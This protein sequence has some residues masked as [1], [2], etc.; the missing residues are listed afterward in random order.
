MDKLPNELLGHVLAFLP[1]RCLA[2]SRRVSLRWKDLCERS[3]C[4]K[5]I[6]NVVIACPG[7]KPFIQGVDNVLVADQ[8]STS[9][10]LGFL[11]HVRKASITFARKIDMK[12]RDERVLIVF[13]ESF[14]KSNK[15]TLESLYINNSSV[16][17]W[18]CLP[19][20][21]LL[22]KFFMDELDAQTLQNLI[23]ACPN[24]EAIRFR[25][26]ESYSFSVLPKGLK[27]MA[28]KHVDDEL[29]GSLDLTLLA[30]SP[31][32]QTIEML[33][34]M[35]L[36]KTVPV[37][38]AMPNLRNAA[39]RVLEEEDMETMPRILST[40][41]NIQELRLRITLRWVDEDVLLRFWNR[42]FSHLKNLLR[43]KLEGC[44]CTQ[45]FGAVG[46]NCTKLQYIN[47]RTYSCDFDQNDLLQLVALDHLKKIEIVTEKLWGPLTPI[48]E[49]AEQ[50]PQ[51]EVK[52]F[53]AVRPM[54]R[55]GN[56]ELMTTQ[57][58]NSL[59]GRGDEFVC[60]IG[61]IR[62]PRHA[63]SSIITI[64]PAAQP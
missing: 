43:L 16:W 1:E 20:M 54:S 24:I 17:A 33:P 32:M 52:M 2:S 63:G 25:N 14:V 51:V 15:E 62:R 49:F 6:V 26:I 28:N 46:A 36:P 55:S 35:S 11:T 37:S 48:R 50:K 53:I 60:D 47:C 4:R 29:H 58:V 39:F 42:V 18:I 10:L 23:A 44:V 9:S 22:R 5:P 13:T 30:T 12:P 38:L 61:P 31:A 40:S 41:P 19:H 34:L 56:G 8:N 57:L 21:P 3:I 27:V 64:R 45:L 59:A 7:V